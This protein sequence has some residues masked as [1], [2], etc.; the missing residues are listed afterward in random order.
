MLYILILSIHSCYIVSCCIIS[1]QLPFL[2]QAD[3]SISISSKNT[4]LLNSWAIQVLQT[5]C[6]VLFICNYHKSKSFQH[7]QTTSRVTPCL[8]HTVF[9]LIEWW[10]FRS[11]VC[12]NSLTQWKQRNDFKW[13]LSRTSIKISTHSFSKLPHFILQ[14]LLKLLSPCNISYTVYAKSFN[15]LNL[16]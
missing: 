16:Q 14:C 7:S 13:N 9:K 5:S 8:N 10:S 15:I 3:I 6:L 11:I 2:N 1:C 4:C 12:I